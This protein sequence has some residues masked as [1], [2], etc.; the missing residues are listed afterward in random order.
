MIQLLEFPHSHFCEKARWA[1][2][3]KGIPFA[4]QPL[5]PGWHIRVVRKIAPRTT[6]PVLLDA[7][8]VVQGSGAIISYLDARF[9]AKPLTIPGEEAR[10]LAFEAELDVA[11]GE[12]IRR[13][14]YHRLLS[15]GEQVRHY[16]MHNS[17][18]Y[19]KQLFRLAFPAIRTLI[20]KKYAIDSKSFAKSSAD[21][22][23]TLD[24]LDARLAHHP[25]LCGDRF[26]R[27]DIAAA[28]LLSFL[29][30]PPE[31]PVPWLPVRD[32]EVAAFRAENAGRPTTL[33]V[34]RMYR[35]HRGR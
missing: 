31:H 7:D 14:L 4:R 26:T 29:P 3:F 34:S 18:A 33:W 27:A 35:E 25:Y 13:V 11:A 1:L 10:I 16:F 15:D 5:F 21:L 2:D 30:M 9:P 8:Q 19:Q 12:S 32:A 6:V 17:P 28:A 24:R 20:R 22:S 23:R